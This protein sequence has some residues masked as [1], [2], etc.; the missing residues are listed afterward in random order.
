MA[1]TTLPKGPQPVKRA[2]A[3]PDLATIAGLV[4]AIA[5]IL[6]GLLLEGGKLQDVAQF[7]A[8]LIVLGGTAGA[9]MVSTPLPVLAGAGRR[10]L[11]V[12]FDAAKPL[13]G[14]ME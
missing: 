2:S 14:L 10:L 12:L 11:G 5:G 3:K 4:I 1:D 9:V 8:A 6:G 7:T 13:D